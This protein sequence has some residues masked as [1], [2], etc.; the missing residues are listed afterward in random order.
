[1]AEAVEKSE[2]ILIFMSE[3]YK[4]SQNCRT[5]AEYAYKKKKKVIPLLVQKGY[6]PD[7]WLGALQGM[8][9]YYRFFTED[10]METDMALLLTAL[11]EQARAYDENDGPIRATQ[12]TK[13][14]AAPAPKSKSPTS[15]WTDKN[16]QDWL[17]KEKLDDLCDT[18]DGLDG[19]H[20]EEM[21]QEY[22]SNANKFKDEMRSDYQM[23]GKLCLK[24]TVALKKLFQK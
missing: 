1:M 19:S 5:E 15:E 10:L 4:N 11:G 17:K 7:G 20:L 21:Y 16:V 6:D 23:N 12:A 2:I 24:F 18:L 3:A 9:L 13:V 8:K 14:H 22:S